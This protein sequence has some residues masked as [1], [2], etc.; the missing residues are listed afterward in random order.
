[1]NNKLFVGNLPYSVTA[2]H[3]TELFSQYGQVLSCK[4]AT[5][6]ETGRPRGFGFVDMQSQQEAQDAITG[7][8]GREL[9]GRQ[10]SVSISQPK[11]KSG[12]GRGRY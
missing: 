11:P 5:D 6:R 3:L 2:E 9:N 8:N 4:I 10:I 12:G 1:M 7:L